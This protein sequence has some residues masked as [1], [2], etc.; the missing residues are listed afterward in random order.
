MDRS[1]VGVKY[2]VRRCTK[3]TRLLSACYLRRR[4]ITSEARPA[5]TTL[6]RMEQFASRAR[7]SAMQ[8]LHFVLRSSGK[9]ETDCVGRASLA[10]SD[11]KATFIIAKV[12]YKESKSK[13]IWNC[14][15]F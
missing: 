2:I 10:K 11:F 14:D 1:L 13:K 7:Y 15:G 3:F 9:V 4:P 12:C 8:V 5:F 6:W